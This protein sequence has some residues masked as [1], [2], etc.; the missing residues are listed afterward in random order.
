MSDQ[1][2]SGDVRMGKSSVYQVTYQSFSNLDKFH[3]AS[4]R[5]TPLHHG[6]LYPYKLTISVDPWWPEV[7][8]VLLIVETE[9]PSSPWGLLS[10]WQIQRV[11]S[12]PAVPRHC[13]Q[14]CAEIRDPW[15]RARLASCAAEC[16]CV[17]GRAAPSVFQPTHVCS[18]LSLFMPL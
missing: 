3:A 12:S 11:P 16:P 18:S 13:P 2:V 14:A 7:P 4:R 10:L 17:H 6:C 8:L 5:L 9:R 1:S 15:A